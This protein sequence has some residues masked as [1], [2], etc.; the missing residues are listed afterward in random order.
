M[1]DSKV[2]V[3]VNFVEGLGVDPLGQVRILL[4][5]VLKDRFE[6]GA[7]FGGFLEEFFVFF[8]E[9]EL[10]TVGDEHEVEDE[11][12]VLGVVAGD[13]DHVAHLL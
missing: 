2:E 7:Y 12:F 1:P 5:P 13:A 3:L 10:E 6:A 11:V 4:G 8:I 9:E